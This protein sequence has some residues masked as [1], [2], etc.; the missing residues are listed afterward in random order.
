MAVAVAAADASAAVADAIGAAV[1]VVT[2]AV[3][4]EV[5][6]DRHRLPLEIGWDRTLVAP[7]RF[8]LGR[9]Q[10]WSFG[11]MESRDAVLLID[12]IFAA[13]VH[14]VFVVDLWLLSQ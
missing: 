1:A 5:S 12:C 13:A 7:I 6:H 3:A 4:I 2:I 11:L 10:V 9:F 8:V 14:A